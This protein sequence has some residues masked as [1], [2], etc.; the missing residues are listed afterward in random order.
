MT[1]PTWQTR[2]DFCETCNCRYICSCSTSNFALPP[3][4]DDCTAILAFHIDSGRFGATPL[5]D[6][7][8]AMVIHTPP[9]SMIEVGWSLGLLIDD[10][11]DRA[12]EDALTA[13]FSGQ[14]GG[15]L[16]GV[17]PLIANFLGV[18]RRP[19]HFEKNGL[20]RSVTIPDALAY[21]IEGFAGPD[22]EPLAIDDPAHPAAARPALARG[23]HGHLRAFGLD[24][25]DETG[26]NNGHFAPFAWSA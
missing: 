11:A 19:I 21:E 5:D 12:Q 6:R 23:K 9:G 20:H 25:R 17:A 26:R 3:N 24:W 14:A 2:G 7:S 4:E 13:I 10:R 18:E 1:T 22:G 8:V 16:G 15:P